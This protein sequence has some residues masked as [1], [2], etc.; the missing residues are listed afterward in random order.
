VR[1][2]SLFLWTSFAFAQKRPDATPLL[3]DVA[4]SFRN[5]TSYRVEGHLSADLDLGFR[6][7]GDY[8]FRI[9]A[10]PQQMR[11]EVTGGPDYATGMPFVAVCEGAKGWVY[12][13][14]VKTYSKLTPD[15]PAD[16]RVHTRDS[17]WL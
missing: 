3:R 10:R 11:I 1:V 17:D 4:S 12:F 7:K 13:E 5:L 16:W 2:I 6:E 15:D 9:A 8:A 14:K